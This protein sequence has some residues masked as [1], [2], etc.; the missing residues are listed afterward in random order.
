MYSTEKLPVD[1]EVG[2]ARS[3]TLR[4]E[5]GGNKD[6]DHGDWANAWLEAR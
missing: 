2:G 3:I 1:V 5:M 4:I 6:C